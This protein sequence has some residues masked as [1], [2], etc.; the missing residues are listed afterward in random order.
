M[1]MLFLFPL[2]NPYIVSS[3]PSEIRVQN[4]GDTVRLNCS[5][6]GTPLPKVTWFKNEKRVISAAAHVG[7]DLIKS[8]LVIHN[9]RPRDDGIY[10]CVFYN[11]KN[12]TAEANS[13]LS[14]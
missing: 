6:G 8:E 11:D 9:F 4:V 12:V 13:S 2:V 10:T 3:P 7:N 5:A 1:L 14:M